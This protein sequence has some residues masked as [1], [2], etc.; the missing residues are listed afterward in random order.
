MAMGCV[1]VV[2]PEV[3]ME[4]YAEPP[5]EGIHYIRV[6]TPEEAKQVVSEI[7][8]EQWK[9]MSQA[10]KAWWKRNCSCEGSFALTKKLIAS[11]K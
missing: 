5:I 1:P 6:Q 2:A 8:E 9:T 4:S 3:D 11:H 7:G 10:C